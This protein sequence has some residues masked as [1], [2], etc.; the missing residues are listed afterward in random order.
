MDPCWAIQLMPW[1]LVGQKKIFTIQDL[2]DERRDTLKK[3]HDLSQQLGFCIPSDRH[4]EIL[5][6][7]SSTWCLQGN[8]ALMQHKWVAHITDG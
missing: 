3:G 6:A 5:T 4:E 2:W 1:V 8:P 7:I